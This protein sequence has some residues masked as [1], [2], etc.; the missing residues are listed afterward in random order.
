MKSVVA[1]LALAPLRAWGSGAPVAKVI[2]MISDLQ[3]KIIKEGDA[4]QKEFAAFSEWC[5]DRS[6]NL[7]FE[8]TTGKSDVEKLTASIAQETA[9]AGSLAAKIDKLAAGLAVDEADLKAATT[10]R[11]KEAADFAATQ[12]DLVET[13][14]TIRRATVILE[15]E[16]SGGASMLQ[17]KNVGG[18]VQAL[19][20]MVDASMLGLADAAKLTAFV[21][22]SQKQ[23]DGDEEVGAPAGS[24]YESHSG[25]I[26]ETLE[27]LLDKAQSQLDAL[28][29]K[30]TSNKQEFEMLRQALEDEIKFATKDMAAAKKESAGSA[31]RKSTAD[32]E[33]KVTSKELASDQDVKATLHQTCMTR[34][35]EFE[36]ETKSRG[37]ELKALADAKK[38][39]KEAVGGAASFLQVD[40]QRMSSSME[41]AGSDALRVIRDVARTENSRVL[42]QLASRLATAMRSGSQDHFAKIKGLISDMIAKLEQEASAD[43]TKKAH[44]DKE[45]KETNQKKAEKTAEIDKLSARIDQATAKSKKLKAEVATLQEELAKLAKAQADMNKLREEEHDTYTASKAEQEKGLAGIKL[46]LKVLKEYYASDAAHDAAVGAGGGI[47][48]LLEV[49]ESDMTKMLAS[50]TYNE[51]AALAEYERISKANEIEKTTKDQDVA[52]KV[53]ESKQLD[54]ESSENS[55]DRSAVQAELD[56]VLEYLAGMEAQCIA[57]P[58]TYAERARRRAAE[59]A[60][61]KEALSILESETALFQRSED[62]RRLR[63][64]A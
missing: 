51:E 44:C 35:Y 40:R 42:A 33:L 37:E 14:D 43:A 25:N 12:K 30:E 9:L 26:V 10:I 57:K 55:A 29:Q 8:I 23:E 63:G 6:S 49:C 5:E 56:A 1:F 2:S 60:G 48:S 22:A 31:E 19:S 11:D 21:Q 61:L 32:G 27:E 50:L 62:H 39:I 3:A 34:A 17:L 7:G 28:R 36:A 53:K 58:E 59:I 24:V 41:S 54:K 16:M 18:L 52:Y 13:I 64:V 47:I 20:V 38:I 46:A 15:R 4:A 45:L